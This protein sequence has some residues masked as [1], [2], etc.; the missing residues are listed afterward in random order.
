M[1]RETHRVLEFT[2]AGAAC[3][4]L[5]VT[6]WQHTT[7]EPVALT[8]VQ[9]TRI[10]NAAK[11]GTFGLEGYHVIL[12]P[13][14]HDPLGSFSRGPQGQNVA[15]PLKLGQSVKNLSIISD[16]EITPTIDQS[17]ALITVKNEIDVA[18]EWSTTMVFRNPD[19]GYFKD[20]FASPNEIT[21]FLKDPNTMPVSFDYEQ[22]AVMEG[23]CTIGLKFDT[24][25][26]KVDENG[27]CYRAS[28]S[29]ASAHKLVASL[30]R[31]IGPLGD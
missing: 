2:G 25:T 18:G 12:K 29:P 3:A 5:A 20:N 19:R 6:L 9:S 30:T 15:A 11:L 28:V 17:G 27:Q 8:H 21:H 24:N 23:Q 4:V 10:A 1:K 22:D 26:V 14:P 13:D 16:T 31:E 7:H